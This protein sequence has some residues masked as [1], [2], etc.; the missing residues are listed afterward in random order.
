MN[1]NEQNAPLVPHFRIWLCGAFRVERRAGDDYEVLRTVE[2]GGSSYPRLLLKALVCCPG[3][4]ARREALLEMLWP[5]TDVEHAVQNLNTAT[6]KLRNVLRPV[7]GQESL[8]LTENDATVYRLEGHQVLWVDVDEALALLKEAEML[9][10]TSPEALRL[11]ERAAG[12]LN[13]GTLLQDE[14]GLWVTGRR[15][16]ID[17]ARYRSRLWLAEA[18]AQQGMP[19][20]AETVLSLLLEEDATDEDVLCRLLLLL[21]R[22]GMT[23]QALRCYERSC[24]IFAR[25]GLEIA[26]A[27]KSV[28]AQ[29]AT[30]EKRRYDPTALIGVFSLADGQKSVLSPLSP[31]PPP[32][33][34]R[35]LVREPGGPDMDIARRRM[36][37]QALGVTSAALATPVN[38]LCHPEIVERLSRALAKPST[39]DEPT[40]RYLAYRTESYWQ[41][42]NSA[43]L[44]SSDLLSYVVEHLQ[45]VLVLL[46]GPLLPAIR[47]RICGIIGTTAMLVGALLYDMSYYA[48]AREFYRAAI[49]AAQEEINP[50]LEA[51]VWGWMSFTWTYEKKPR[52]ALPCIQ[53][54][55]HLAAGSSNRMICAWLAAVEAEI[56]ANLG[57]LDACLSAFRDTEAL[58]EH[59]SSLEDSYWIHFDRSLLAGYKGICFRR[60]YRKEDATTHSFLQD[61]QNSL[62]EALDRLNPALIRRSP[63]YH[64]DIAATYIPQGDIELACNHALQ[65]TTIVA[66]IKAQTVLQRLLTLRKDLEPWK[67]TQWVKNVDSHMAPLLTSG[68]YRDIV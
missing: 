3:R 41:D 64:V 8:L 9:G 61:A 49:K 45:K 55:R 46:E 63:Q 19:G 5:D 57:D 27:T 6:T 17:Q 30:S 28:A 31:I 13:K 34:M 52:H 12:S 37:Q 51:I 4:Q 18:Y 7:K 38:A 1:N 58:E 15:A 25:E 20:Q 2:W 60:F 44:A 50:R 39:I 22:Q 29:L 21:H 68:W 16:T 67:D 35:E 56:Q 62:I 36:L 66:Q 43:A 24:Q 14:E 10:R 59:P 32:A 65:A 23:H 54:A 40:L 26:E 47:T 33:I 53:K 48:E 11:L 42:R